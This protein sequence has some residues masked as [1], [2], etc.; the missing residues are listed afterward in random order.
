MIEQIAIAFFGLSAIWLSQSA[1]EASRKWAPIL[2][3]SSQP[4]WFYATLT[5]EQWGIFVLSLFYTLAWMRGVKNHW[6]S[7]AA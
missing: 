2:G 5:A 3:L 6:M 1:R 7:K 4:F